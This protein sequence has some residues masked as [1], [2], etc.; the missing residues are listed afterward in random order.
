MENNYDLIIVGGGPAGMTAGIYASRLGL[1]SFLV[2][3]S[4]G[5]QIAS[6]P[7]AIDN[8][9]GFD[10]IEGIELIKKMEKHLKGLDIDINLDEVVALESIKK[11]FLVKLK[12]GEEFT[13]K[14]IIATSGAE[15]KQL[16]IPG[17]KEFTGKGVSYCAICD[18]PIFKGKTVAIIGGGNV[19]FET[20]IFMSNIAEKIYVLEYSDQVKAFNKIVKLAQESGKIKIITNAIAKKIKGEKFVKS[21]I[22][23]DLKENIEKELFAQ[24][25]FIVIGYKPVVQYLQKLVEFNSVGEI[26][27]NCETMETSV[28]GIF[29]AGDVTSGI[30]KQIVISA[31]EGA[32]SA[33]SAYKYIKRSNIEK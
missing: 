10:S 7:V 4:F 31:G 2:T 1:K 8:Y 6:K 19:G 27:V 20:A 11:G 14:S 18:G 17:E 22:Y 33:L 5:G 12:G 29:A 30:Y 16:N 15:A 3:K 21:L 9:P 26:I 28:P 32:K 25:V 13:A 23:K 24:G